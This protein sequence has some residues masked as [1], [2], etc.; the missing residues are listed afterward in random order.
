MINLTRQ[1]GEID[2]HLHKE[3][4]VSLAEK[5]GQLI[6]DNDDQ[7]ILSVYVELKRYET[8]IRGLIEHLKGPALEKALESGEDKFSYD[9]A[10]VRI[11]HRV[12]WDFSS[13]SGWIEIHQ[14]IKELISEKK[15]REIF[16]KENNNEPS[17]I[18]PE[19][20]EVL[21]GFS[22]SKEV[23]QGIAIQF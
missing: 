18:D 9:D 8:Y 11:T 15:E 14:L 5:H 19:T 3:E 10:I 1:I 4:I 21:E 2:Q 16:L 20:G 17:V 22:L 12:A 23:T 13:D 6:I 7:D